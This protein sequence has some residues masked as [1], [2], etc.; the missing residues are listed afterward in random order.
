LKSSSPVPS[1]AIESQVGA[2]GS[3]I[4]RTRYE[5]AVGI[6]VV[7]IDYE[8][9]PRYSHFLASQ[10]QALIFH[11]PGWLNALAVESRSKCLMLA[12]E[13]AAGGL[14]GI[15]PLMH[16]RGL[17]FNIGA[18][19]TGRRLAS[20]PRTPDAGVVCTDDDAFVMLLRFALAKAGADRIRLQIKST[21]NL[22]T[23]KVEGI[24]LTNWRP[25]YLVNIPERPEDLQFGDAR[26]RHNLRWGVKKAEKGGLRVRPAGSEAELDAWYPAYLATMR[27]NVVPP[28]SLRFFR[29]L[30]RELAP[31]GLMHLQLAEQVIHNQRRLVAGSIFLQFGERIWYAFTGVADRDLPLHPNDLILWSAIHKACG[32]GVR[33]MDLG[34]VAE[35][36]PE[37]IRF[38]TKWG[39]YPV[40]QYRYYAAGLSQQS[41]TAAKVSSGTIGLLRG[42]WQH[43]PLVVTGH[44]GDLIYSRL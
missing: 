13:N 17:P 4:T 44:L 34:E 14:E 27:R 18:Q 19:Q 2:H 35:E 40:P 37:L 5:R 15:L 43:L 39:A 42:C 7:E 22:P 8:N 24:V 12:C 41:V 30:W 10:P 31:R 28:R 1:A 11:H 32:T 6:R 16:T 9:D 38:K 23:E 29:A 33:W 25:T 20:L 21:R 36:H 3:Q 26:N